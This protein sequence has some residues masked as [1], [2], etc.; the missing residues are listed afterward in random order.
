MGGRA[1]VVTGLPA[2]GKTTIARALVA[3]LS[4]AFLDKD[5]FLE[6]LFAERG[7]GSRQHRAELSRRSDGLFQEEARVQQ[8]V[9]LASHWRP[10]IGPTD[11]GTPTAWL[12][13]AFAE[14]VEVCCVC[15]PETAIERFLSR[16]RHAGHLDGERDPVSLAEWMRTLAPGYPL[17]VG[18]LVRVGTERDVDATELA[19]RVRR[20]LQSRTSCP[21]P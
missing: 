4:F 2:S 6:R 17:G 20:A 13:D 16:R 12:A 9:V 14:I 18:A 15:A 5:D 10:R 1:D 7:A 11:T 19:D 8:A 3:S 21:T